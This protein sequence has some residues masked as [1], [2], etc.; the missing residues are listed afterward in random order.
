M[1]RFLLKVLLVI[2]IYFI[3]LSFFKDV[4]SVVEEDGNVSDAEILL[5]SRL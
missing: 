2:D 3:F 5:H 1:K 4:N